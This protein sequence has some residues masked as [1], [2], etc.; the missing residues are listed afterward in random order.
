MRQCVFYK[1]AGRT[2]GVLASK[3]E[4]VA[5]IFRCVWRHLIKKGS[6]NACERKC[7][8]PPCSALQFDAVHRLQHKLHNNTVHSSAKTNRPCFWLD[9]YSA[10]KLG[11]PGCCN[12]KTMN[13]VR[14]V[15]CSLQ[16]VAL[17]GAAYWILARF[18]KC[19]WTQSCTQLLSCP[20][21]FFVNKWTTVAL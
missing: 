6:A 1:A 10:F 3:C 15:Y 9:H 16:V 8:K 17:V 20:V 11:L 18:K 12:A 5:R 2:I 14:H 7:A 19:Y 21:V 4:R 13:E